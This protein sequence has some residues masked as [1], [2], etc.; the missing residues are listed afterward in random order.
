MN[1]SKF[2]LLTFYILT[3]HAAACNDAKC[4]RNFGRFIWGLGGVISTTQFVSSTG[5]CSALGAHEQAR[6]E[7]YVINFDKISTD[8]AK[9]G[10][11]YASTFLSLSNCFEHENED[12]FTNLQK[13]YK[14]VSDDIEASYSETVLIVE[15]R[16]QKGT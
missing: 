2:F 15:S 3:S 4:T 8:F 11:E 5:D 9:G 7:F 16:C 6:Q 10:G 13:D 1:Y 14:N 12:L